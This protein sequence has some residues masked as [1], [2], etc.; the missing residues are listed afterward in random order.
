MARAVQRRSFGARKNVNYTWSTFVTPT[1]ITVPAATKILLGFFFLD[2]A[3]EET[4]T[5]VRGHVTVVSDQVTSPLE[6]QVGAFGM[7][8]VTDRAIAAGAASIP[9]PVTDGDD[10]GWFLWVP[11]AQIGALTVDS[12]QTPPYLVDSKAQRIVREGQQLA[13]MVENASV[14]NGLI[15]IVSLRALSRFRS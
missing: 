3:F 10:D 11:F 5:R 1:G 9:G 8:R 15:I 4:V 2:T 14:T 13:V 12:G 7:I 6:A